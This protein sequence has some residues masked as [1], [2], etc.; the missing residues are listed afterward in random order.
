MKT[1]FKV[2]DCMTM[3][4]IFVSQNDSLVEISKVMANNHV[5]AVLVKE[6]KKFLGIITEQDIVRKAVRFGLDPN[7]TNAG[8]IVEKVMTTIEPDEDIFDALTM[9]REKNIRHLPVMHKDNLVGLL[10]VKDILK[11]QPQLFEILVDRLEVRESERKA[12]LLPK[13][14]EGICNICGR[15]AEEVFLVK[16]SYVCDR[17]KTSV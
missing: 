17:C 7:K 1:G 3:S 13:E 11:I 15:Y 12:S 8:K 2:G 14:K 9:L 5:G 4:P 10:T 16:G 6:D